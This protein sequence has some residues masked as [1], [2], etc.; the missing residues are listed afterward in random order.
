MKIKFIVVLI[1]F[2]FFLYGSVDAAQKWM[3]VPGV[4]HVQ[5]DFDGTDC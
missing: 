4:I 2:I 5:T 1:F 3:Q